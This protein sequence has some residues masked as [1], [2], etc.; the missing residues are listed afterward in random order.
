MI[1]RIGT[2]GR[3]QLTGVFRWDYLREL[4]L[5]TERLETYIGWSPVLVRV[6]EF[7]KKSYSASLNT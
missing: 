6:E 4:K 1:G 7:T 5:S 2:G 3:R